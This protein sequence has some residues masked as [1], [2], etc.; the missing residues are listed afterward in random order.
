MKKR[1]STIIGAL[2][3]LCLAT[4]CFVGSTFAKYTSESSGTAITEIAKWSFN[5]GDTNITTSATFDIDTTKTIV[6]TVDSNTDAHVATGKMAPGTKGTY[7]FTVTNTSDVV[8]DVTFTITNSLVGTNIESPI[9]L[10][11]V[12]AES[13]SSSREIELENGTYVIANVAINEAVTVTVNWSWAFDGDDTA[14]GIAAA[15]AQ[16][17]SEIKWQTVIDL[18][19]TQVD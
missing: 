4:S 11:D 15:A 5:I 8:A 13:N 12:T 9:Q 6:D 19:A 2:V 16:A 14:L 17:G 18:T 7:T 10:G 3:V 1:T